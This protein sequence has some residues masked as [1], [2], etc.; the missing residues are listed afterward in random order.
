M[1]SSSACSRAS[2]LGALAR[3]VAL[4]EQLD[5]LELLERL[6]ELRLGVVKL[7]LELVGRALEVFAPRHRG[8][9]IG[10]IGEMRRIVDP[11]AV[12]LGLDLALEVD[13]HAVEL[14]DHALDLSDPPA[15]LVDLEFLRQIN[16][17]RD[18]IGSFS[19]DAK[20]PWGHLVHKQPPGERLR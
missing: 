20:P 15:L 1:A 9:G 18:F 8:L 12:L 7:G 14:G 3:L 6:A 2:I 19:P 4:V 10:R 5:L 11:G 16:V 17:S 13:R